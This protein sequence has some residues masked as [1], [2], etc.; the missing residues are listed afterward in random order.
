MK[1]SFH[2]VSYFKDVSFQVR[3]LV[4]LFFYCFLFG[5]IDKIKLDFFPEDLRQPAQ[6]CQQ[7]K[8]TRKPLSQ[9]TKKNENQMEAQKKEKEKCKKGQESK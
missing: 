7:G 4:W 5:K 6:L 3:F 1:P 9:N 8:I 2:R